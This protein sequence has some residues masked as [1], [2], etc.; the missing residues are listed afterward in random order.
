VTTYRISELAQRVGL[1][2]STLRFYE[3]AGLV[4]A[5]RSDSGYRLFDD[6]A[7]DRIQIIA[8]GKRLGLSLV[9]IR[10][11]LEAWESG[12]CRDVRQRL[13]PMVANHI[14]EAGQ[15]V[16]EISRLTDRLRTAAS[17]IDGPAPSGR[18]GPG[19]GIVAREDPAAVPAALERAIQRQDA[20]PGPPIACTLTAADR[21]DRI[22]QWRRLLGQADEREPVD[23]GLAFGFP[24]GLAGRL[25]ELAA[26]EQQCCTFLE[27]RL[28]LRAGLVRF[29]VRAPADGVALLA[30]LF[31][32]DEAPR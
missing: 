11:L 32:A 31:Q 14:A 9:E 15:R 7:V 24:A 16:A 21:A 19:C 26:A 30:S 1:P 23:G 29:E 5:R 18:C 4:P 27:F 12:P 10:D 25:A 13:R 20:E 17:V 22:G 3:Q 8:T 28:Y 6:Q 2:A